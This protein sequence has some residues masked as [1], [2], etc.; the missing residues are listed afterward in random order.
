MGSIG[1]NLSNTSGTQDEEYDLW[2]PYPEDTFG[3]DFVPEPGRIISCFR[4]QCK[5]C[6]L[7]SLVGLASFNIA[8]IIIIM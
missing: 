2:R 4:E 3:P 5:L 6:Q 8:L 7:F 1:R